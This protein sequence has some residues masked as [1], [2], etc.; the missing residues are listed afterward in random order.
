M[1]GLKSDKEGTKAVF[2]SNWAEK[3]NRDFLRFDYR[4][5]GNSSGS[6]ED[7]SISDWLDDTIKIIMELT[8]GPQILVGSSLGGWISLLFARLYPQKVAGI[9]GIAA[10]PDFTSK[11][12]TNNLTLEQRRELKNTGKLSFH[13]EYF[14][15]EISESAYQSQ[16]EIDSKKNIIVG[17]NEY[18]VEDEPSIPLLTVDTQGLEFQIS[19]LEKIKRERNEKAVSIK[20]KELRS[21][22]ISD[23][24]LMPLL[25]ETVKEYATLGEIMDVFREVFGEHSPNNMF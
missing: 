6:F 20:L 7:T 3:N 9:I 22:A 24:N 4:G 15:R 10:A 14:E 11:Y 21:A 8:S 5:H 23:Q 1:S 12:S 18:Q 2:L 19:E 13:S 16:Q 17:V 25:V